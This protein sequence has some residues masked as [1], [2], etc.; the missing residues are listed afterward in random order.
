M[1]IENA[2]RSFAIDRKHWLF[3]D[4]VDGANAS[5]T[6]YRIIE[7]A[8]ANRHELYNYLRYALQEIPKAASF[9]DFE[10]LLPYNLKPVN[11]VQDVVD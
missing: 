10:K 11:I 4:T 9:K 1:R 8:K 6:I 3:S 2:I 5:A 7:T